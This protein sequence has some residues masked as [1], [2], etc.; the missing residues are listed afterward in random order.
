MFSF[1]QEAVAAVDAYFKA[2][3]QLEH[4][5]MECINIKEDCVKNDSF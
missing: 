5:L 2:M 4:R 3:S 1:N